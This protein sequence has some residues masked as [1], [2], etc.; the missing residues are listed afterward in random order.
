MTS[1]LGAT[2]H[3]DPHQARLALTREPVPERVFGEW[4]DQ[5]RRHSCGSD[6]GRHF[7]DGLQTIAKSGALDRK[8]V[9]T[10]AISSATR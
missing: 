7:D 5:Q 2:V 8:N 1:S 3:A 4:Q 10:R 6:I 9:S